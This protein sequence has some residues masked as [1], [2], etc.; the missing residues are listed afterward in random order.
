MFRRILP[1]QIVCIAL[2]LPGA[3]LHRPL[4]QQKLTAVPAGPFH[5]AGN[6]IVDA[7]GQPFL[8]RGTQLPG[9]HLPAALSRT[10]GQ[11][12][13]PYSATTLSTIRLRFNMNA[14]R[15]PVNV[16]D[17][18]SDPAWL[19]ELSRVVR[20]ANELELL[21]ILAAQQP[22][23]DLPSRK[24]AHFWSRCAAF[25]KDYPNVFFDAFSEPDAGAVPGY[26]AGR[27]AA[28]DWQFWLH[29]GRTNDGREAIGF[30]DLVKTIRATGASQPIV[31]MGWH[32]DGLLEGMTPEFFINDP[33]I[34]YEV[35]PRY[36]TTRT[37]ADRNAHFGFLAARVPVLANNWD[38]ELDRY[39]ADCL[40]I[41]PDPTVAEDMVKAN[42]NY[43]DAHGISWTAS[44]FQPGKLITDY[45]YLFATTLEDGWTCGEPDAPLA[46]MGIAVQFHLWS[47]EIRGLFTVTNPTGGMV[48]AR[49][50]IAAAYGPIG[51]E[52][53]LGSGRAPLPTTLG[54]ISV[55]VTDALGVAR[56]A[57]LLHMSA[58]WGYI[59]FIVPSGSSPGP[60][61]I[62]IL[63]SDGTS[64]VG[65]ATIANVSPGLYTA[66]QD[67]HGP[68]IGWVTQKS[69]DGRT[70]TFP[71]YK[72]RALDCRTVPI[73]LSDEVTTTV[74]LNGTGFRHAGPAPDVR[75]TIGD[76][77]VPV[78]SIHPASDPGVDELTIQLPRKLGSLGETDL[79]LSVNG[80]LANVVRINV[81]S[82]K[83]R[84]S[85]GPGR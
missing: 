55:R 59:N 36:R 60:A 45:R 18:S 54:N 64:A 76:I 73:P 1:L 47:A 28:S 38:L 66:P 49:G 78:V 65:N 52:A 9:F 58:G 56:L 80:R 44:V 81:Q 19:P 11:Q 34:V 29:G 39:S 40:A 35:C 67:G 61:E 48:L 2:Q 4:P 20:R 8:I 32:D 5:V 71:A 84:A 53:E 27:H 69:V 30:E 25:F 42:L 12:F 43:F 85:G 63:R 3:S 6:R 77:R 24:V 79:L 21:V 51:A 68:V 75:V 83:P 82:K 14:V 31:A 50:G 17:D 10:V 57:P 62:A 7:K 72:C 13:G 16:A 46:G 26:L 70:E 22:G 23:T 15:I 37:D 74:R 33:N 41:P